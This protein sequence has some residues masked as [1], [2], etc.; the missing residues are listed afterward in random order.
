MSTPNPA[1]AAGDSPTPRLTE[2]FC[3]LYEE[4]RL[5]HL[6]DFEHYR[7]A[8][9]QTAELARQL[10]RELE[11][12]MKNHG[13]TPAEVAALRAELAA[14]RE[15]NERLQARDLALS[16]ENGGLNEQ[17]AAAVAERDKE[18]TVASEALRLLL[19]P[20]SKAQADLQ[21][22]LARVERLKGALVKAKIPHQVVEGD[23]WFSCPASGDCCND[24]AGTECNCG[25]D[26][27]NNAIEQALADD[28][29]GAQK[30]E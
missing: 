30:S 20:N 29:Q 10:A 24:N 4:H 26:A 13:A 8:F 19:L 5:A 25:A 17:L 6:D 28:A 21:S 18:K 16:V 2:F 3:K 11:T 14:A 23:C 22:A 12:A 15:E 7:D 9:G 1:P 27:H